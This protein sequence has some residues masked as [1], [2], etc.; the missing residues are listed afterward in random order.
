MNRR[1]RYAALLV[2][3]FLSTGAAVADLDQE[4][5]AAYARGDYLTAERAFSEAIT[6][7]PSDALLRYHRAASLTQLGRWDE[8]VAEYERVLKLRPA[9][10]VAGASRTALQNRRAVPRPAPTQHRNDE[11]EAISRLERSS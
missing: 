7:S 5:R 3:L 2:I 6:R 9:E 11:V 1:G 10:Q 4:G 8:A